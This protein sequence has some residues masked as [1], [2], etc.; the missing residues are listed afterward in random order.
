MSAPFSNAR[1]RS[2]TVAEKLA[3]RRSIAAKPAPCSPYPGS[4][5]IHQTAGAQ[6]IPDRTAPDAQSPPGPT[7][8]SRTETG[9]GRLMDMLHRWS[10]RPG[11][12]GTSNQAWHQQRQPQRHHD[13]QH[14][15]DRQQRSEPVRRNT[16]DVRQ[17]QRPQSD[18]DHQL[19]HFSG[20]GWLGP[21]RVWRQVAGGKQRHQQGNADFNGH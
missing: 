13:D 18:G 5:G 10:M 9:N 12:R 11:R 8:R 7:P 6:R 3:T 19:Q 4:D 14:A 16:A 21:A 1:R 2:A 15:A 20:M 17:E